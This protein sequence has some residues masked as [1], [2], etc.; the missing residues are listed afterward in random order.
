MK[1]M[2][3]PKRF[4]IFVPLLIL[5]MAACGKTYHKNNAIR[6]VNTVPIIESLSPEPTASPIISETI[7]DDSSTTT[8]QNETI[9]TV[10]EIFY[11]NQ[12]DTTTKIIYE[13]NESGHLLR[14]IT[15]IA[16][17]NTTDD[18]A[19]GNYEQA[20][21]HGIIHY[22]STTINQL[23][24]TEMKE[25][26]TV[27]IK[28]LAPLYQQAREIYGRYGVVILLADKII[29]MNDQAEYCYEY[30]KIQDSLNI[31][32]RCLDC[33]PT[34]FFN[35]LSN[36]SEQ[37]IPCIQ[38]VESG[39]FSGVYYG[40]DKYKLIQLD[41]NNY[42]PYETYDDKGEYFCYTLHHEISHMISDILLNR[43]KHSICSLTE[44]QWNSFNPK[45]FEYA[46]IYN[47][48][49]EIAIYDTNNY[50]EYFINSYGCLTPDEDRATIFGEAMTFYQGYERNPF[51]KYT[52]AKL[53]YYSNCIK[54]EFHNDNWPDFVP[55]ELIIN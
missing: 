31:I 19:V 10:E 48:N 20:D 44:K 2:I 40:G 14:E 8:P 52:K 25:V 50:K 12:T 51:T 55:W 45:D 47:S 15:Y 27:T 17:G 5:L 22:D 21:N 36:E 42:T 39:T 32:R 41:V 11:D 38:L 28:E 16:D 4:L 26:F 1:Q 18:F 6:L 13:Y 54:A 3:S 7:T 35:S 46:N 53:K 49:K 30:D 23:T 9:T 33:Y 43:A 37:I 29:H 24:D 34:N